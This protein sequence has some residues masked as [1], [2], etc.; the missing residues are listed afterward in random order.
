MGSNKIQGE[1]WGKNPEDWALIQEAT[2]SAGYKHVFDFLDLKSTDKLLDVGCG[3]GFFSNLA[4]LKGINVV[5]ID[6]SA[7]LIEQAKKR[8]SQI[9][10]HIGEM[11]ELPFEDN[12]FD[13]VCAFNSIQYA[14]SVKSAILESKRTLKEK[15]KLVIMIWGNKEDCEAGSFLKVIGSLLPPPPPGA[16]GPFAL[17]ENEL[18]ENIIA[19][20]GL[21][22]I[23]N[24]DVTSVWDYPNAE[25][26]LKGILSA[27]PTAKAI[28]NSGFEKV[29]EE[30]AKAIKPYTTDNGHVVYKNKFRVVISE[31]E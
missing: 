19:E 2:G 26:A 10:F 29:Y 27:G 18:L 7:P 16:G 24:T 6:A 17:S 4:Y 30:S 14:E 11:E 3:S 12:T 15:G 8:N 5:G 28:N 13:I 1:L 22:I 21:R 9:E 23:D 20:C 31:K 25:T